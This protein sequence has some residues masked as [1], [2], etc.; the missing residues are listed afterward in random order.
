[1]EL[2]GY[3]RSSAAYRIRLALNV[4]EVPY[5]QKFLSLVT[6][7]Q[8]ES[9]Y[10]SKNPQGLVP[11]LQDGAVG[12]AQSMAML[13]HLEEHYP[14]NPLLPKD[15]AGRARVRQLANIIACDIHPLDNLRVLKYITGE[16]G[17]TEEQKTTWYHHWIIEGFKAFEILLETGDKGLYCHGDK[18]TFADVLLIPQIYNARRFKCPLE[19]FPNI[20]RIDENCNK[21][22]SFIDAGP[23]IQ[24]DA[25]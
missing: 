7:E 6:G 14:E 25:S 3:F 19:D 17:V 13:E 5:D 10:L 8:R 18:I 24:P 22:Q 2:T 11:F 23:D 9:E 15:A 4:K 1:M 21:L 20:L 16:L 12:M